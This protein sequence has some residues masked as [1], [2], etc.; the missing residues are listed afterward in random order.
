MK[1][2]TRKNRQTGTTIHIEPSDN[3]PFWTTICDDHGFCCDHGTK[4][5]AIEWAAEPA[6]WCEGCA[7]IKAQTVTA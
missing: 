5:L 7:Q 6:V 2:L 4:R 3:G 1:T